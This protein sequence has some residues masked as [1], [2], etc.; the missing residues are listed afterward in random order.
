MDRTSVTSTN[1][2]PGSVVHNNHVLVCSLCRK[3]F[4]DAP[5]TDAL[6]SYN[7]SNPMINHPVVAEA[8]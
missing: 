7:E 8:S 4:S 1:D 2:Q 5:C 6:P 3:Y